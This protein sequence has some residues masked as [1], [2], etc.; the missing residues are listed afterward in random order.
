MLNGQMHHRLE[1]STMLSV[2][3]W[4]DQF[5]NRVQKAVADYMP[6]TEERKE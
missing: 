2:N 4:P 5:Y 6:E 3:K 1:D